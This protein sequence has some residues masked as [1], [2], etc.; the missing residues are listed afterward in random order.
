MWATY[1]GLLPKLPWSTQVCPS[2]D[3]V[4]RWHGCR[5][6]G[7][8]VV[9]G[10]G[11]GSATARDPV[12]LL[13]RCMGKPVATGTRDLAPVGAFPSAQQPL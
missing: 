5:V 3:R 8:P 12:P 6:M 9:T 11:G 7:A 4:W 2:K 1:R 13:R 10:V